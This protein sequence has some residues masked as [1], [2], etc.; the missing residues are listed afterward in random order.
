MIYSFGTVNEA[1]GVKGKVLKAVYDKALEI[2]SN[3]DRY[4]GKDRDIYQNDGGFVFIA[5]NKKDLD[6]FIENH[7]DPRKGS[8]EDIRIIRAENL[9]YF[10]MFFLCNNEFCINLIFPVNL[11]P[12]LKANVQR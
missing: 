5:E 8:Y 11:M 9:Q 12:K 1:H 7:I 6:Y 2:V 3:L 10:N 4:Y